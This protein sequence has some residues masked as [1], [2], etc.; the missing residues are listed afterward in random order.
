MENK[1]KV[2]EKGAWL[3]VFIFFNLK[4]FQHRKVQMSEALYGELRL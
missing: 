1:K 4:L 2:P 3:V